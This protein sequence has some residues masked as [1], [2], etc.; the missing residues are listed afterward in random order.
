MPGTPHTASP[1]HAIPRIRRMPY[2]ERGARHGA[3]RQPPFIRRLSLLAVHRVINWM[4][5]VS[6]CR[7]SLR[8]RIFI[9]PTPFR[10]AKGDN[11]RRRWASPFA[12]GHARFFVLDRPE[13][14]PKLSRVRTELQAFLSVPGPISSSCRAPQ[15]LA[16]SHIGRQPGAEPPRQSRRALYRRRPRA[17]PPAR[18]TGSFLFLIGVRDRKAFLRWLVAQGEFG[19]LQLG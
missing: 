6:Y 16:K 7:L 14:T 17:S 5:E 2:R 18:V 8:E 9:S 11:R 13:H 4:I 3:R 12:N 15:Q 19:G 10:G 1:A